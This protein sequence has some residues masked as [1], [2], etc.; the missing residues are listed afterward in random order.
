VFRIAEMGYA[1]RAGNVYPRWAPDFFYGYGFPIFNFYAPLT[2]LAANLVSLAHPHRAVGAAKVVFVGGLLCAGVGMFLLMR[3]KAGQS[4]G[5]VAAASFL[6]SPYVFLI[7]PHIRGALPECFALGVSP[8]F[9]WALA[10]F[11]DHGDRRHWVAVSLLTAAVLLSHNLVGLM[12]ALLGTTALVWR[13]VVEFPMRHKPF[14]L[15][16]WKRSLPLGI[17]AGLSAFFWLPVIL[18]RRSVQLGRL[19]G[20]AY[21]HYDNHFL[22]LREILGPSVRLDLGAGNPEVRFNL[23]VPQWLLAAAGLVTLVLLSRREPRRRTPARYTET[24]DGLFWGLS[25]VGF[26]FLMTALS[27]PVWKVLS[28]MAF[29]QFPWRFLG[30]AALCASVLAGYST[31]ALQLLRLRWRKW[32]FVLLIGLP[33]LGALPIFAP[34]PWGD[35][36]PT[37][38]RAMIDFE[39][40]GIA[41]GTT[42]AG[43]YLPSTAHRVPRPQPAMIEAYRRGQ[44]VDR[45]DRRALPEGASVKLLSEFPSGEA[46][47]ITSPCAFTLRFWRFMYPG[48]RVAVDG[49]PTQIRL[50]SPEGFLALPVPAG[51]HT[52]TVWFGTTVARTLGWLLSAASLSALLIGRRCIAMVPRSRPNL[53]GFSRIPALAFVF[54]FAGLVAL[55]NHIGLLQPRSTGVVVSGADHLFHQTFA[56]GI[57]LLGYAIAPTAQQRPGAELTLTLFW[58]ARQAVTTNYRVFV[59]LIDANANLWTQSDKEHPADYPTTRWDRDRYV[60][61]VHR[62]QLPTT[63]PPGNYSLRVGLWT[64]SNGIR[65]SVID[66]DGVPIGDSTSLPTRV[67]VTAK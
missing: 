49:S 9:L 12:V 19:I 65:Q 63:M 14:W 61:D 46:Y 17:G 2:Y 51:V 5:V 45:I 55:G 25:L 54:G 50:D 28:P 10:A 36:G 37:D 30:P 59:H 43:E 47:G 29:V 62:M 1:L 34:P 67:V 57:D 42:A 58:K 33:L 11:L 15:S 3:H 22:K 48:W 20:P 8:L 6:F 39:V 24:H 7:D 26:C 35:F 16:V 18:E 66:Q 64:L 44:R 53:E 4:A 56:G 13:S 23:G 32:V 27:R 60:R 38:R 40:R 41:V 52:V 31:R 21:Y